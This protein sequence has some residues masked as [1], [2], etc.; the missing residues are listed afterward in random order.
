VVEDSL[1]EVGLLAAYCAQDLHAHE[2]KRKVD[3]LQLQQTGWPD[4]ACQ[5]PRVQV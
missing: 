1:A 3:G 2:H 5:G 4:P